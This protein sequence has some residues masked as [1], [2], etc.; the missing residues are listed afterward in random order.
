VV[1]DLATPVRTEPEAEPP[2]LFV[3]VE[4]RI[5]E[6]A[7]VVRV[8]LQT[9][10]QRWILTEPARGAWSVLE[11]RDDQGEIRY[12]VESDRARVL[13]LGRPPEGRVHLVYR[14]EAPPSS[15]GGASDP[16]FHVDA[17]EGLIHAVGESILWLP[18][19]AVPVSCRLEIDAPRSEVATSLGL[20]R[21]VERELSPMALRRV[22]ILVGP[23]QTARFRLPDAEDDVAALGSTS[24]DLRWVAAETAGVRSAVGAYFGAFDQARFTTLVVTGPRAS[25]APAYAVGLRTHGLVIDGAPWAPWSADA[26]LRVATALAHRWLGGRVRIDMPG[27]PGE[28]VWFTQGF[29]RHVAR[30][31][32]FGLGLLTD[33]DMLAELDG[34]E[35]AVAT[36][37]LKGMDNAR[38]V[39]E[40]TPEAV[41][42]VVTRGAL[43]AGRLAS[44]AATHS[45]GNH[46]LEGLL[47]VLVR[48]ARQT[49]GDIALATWERHLEA[50]AG[51]DEVDAFRAMVLDGAPL[52]VPADAFGPCFE[53]ARGRYVPFELGFVDPG[54]RGD[55]IVAEQVDPGGPAYEAGLR[56]GDTIVELVYRPGD[57]S[58]S[59]ILAVERDGERTHADYAPR[60]QPVVGRRWLRDRRVPDEACLR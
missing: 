46:S 60:G 41:A 40:G 16:R 5:S 28:G 33:E 54:F 44:R 14:I 8:E 6:A 3:R 9:R 30:E 1:P 57:P 29:S 39:A 10:A 34:L 19:D 4:P 2:Q 25:N 47:A 31:V 45:Q 7:V 52:Q 50:L 53:P 21:T 20:G 18:D 26:R 48:D 56:E 24:F 49:G 59:V 35:S 11:L 38:L 58:V 22:D 27:A 43:Y 15:E 23:L 37:R 17:R 32:L 12:A 51:A 55:P 36:S 13:S 42:L